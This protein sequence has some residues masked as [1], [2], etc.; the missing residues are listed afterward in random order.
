MKVDSMAKREATIIAIS[1]SILLAIVIGTALQY[2]WSGIGVSAPTNPSVHQSSRKEMP[3]DVKQLLSASEQN[4][5][6]F[7]ENKE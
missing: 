6:Q 7:L 2:L 1:G 3:A 5:S 4:R